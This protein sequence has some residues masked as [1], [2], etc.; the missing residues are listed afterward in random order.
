MPI[1]AT[2]VIQVQQLQ[3]SYGQQAVL[4]NLDLTVMPGELIAIL[5]PNG[6][7]KTTLISTLLGLTDCS[8]GTINLLGQP[9]GK[10]RSLQLK[11]QLGV[12]M[13][14]GTASANLTVA[15]QCDLFSSYYPNGKTT[16]ELLT[17]AG[18]APQVKVRFGKLSGGQKQ[19]LL[20]A[21]ALAGNPKLLFLDEPTLGMDVAARQALWQQIR[22]LKKAGV[23][24]VLTTHYLQ[25][26]EQLS[27][28]ILVLQHGRFIAQGSSAELKALS[29]GKLIRCRCS[30]S[31][32][33]LSALPG[34]SSIQREHDRI[35]LQSNHTEKTVL[36]L[37]QADDQ[38]SELE[39]QPIALEQAFLQLT[40]Q[41]HA[42]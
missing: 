3:K 11:Q 13:Q 8:A 7:G 16:D 23:S 17:I 12:M 6:A 41:E 34:V 26:A 2:A 24:I 28:R 18:L 36:A 21:L 14:V 25:E 37:L 39:V 10:F 4:N 38:V 27:D 35:I 32:E 1:S 33:T 5:G 19:R 30:L 9:Q 31:D 42:V 20:F 15:E 40:S 29:N 22:E